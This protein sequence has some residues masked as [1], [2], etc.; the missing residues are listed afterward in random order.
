MPVSTGIHLLSGD[1]SD[2]EDAKAS[3]RE[4]NAATDKSRFAHK[5]F[6]GATLV[7]AQM[8]SHLRENDN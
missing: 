5:P 8:D 2:A 1:A 4:E 3:Q 7:V 6:V